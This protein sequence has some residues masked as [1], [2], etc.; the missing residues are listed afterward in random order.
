MA[1]ILVEAKQLVDADCKAVKDQALYDKLRSELGLSVNDEIA[2]AL[3]VID[4]GSSEPRYMML[5][6]PQRKP[7]PVIWNHP[8]QKD[9]PT[10]TQLTPENGDVL[11]ITY[12][13]PPGDLYKG[14]C[15]KIG[16]I[17]VWF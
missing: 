2:F 10:G 7:V 6:S 14:F 12:P 15:T 1:E 9:F 4:N 16:G 8:G 11:S 3:L 5:T 13:G 17:P